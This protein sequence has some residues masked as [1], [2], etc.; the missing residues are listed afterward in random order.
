MFKSPIKREELVF[1]ASL[2]AQLIKTLRQVSDR[3]EFQFTFKCP[4]CRKA[5]PTNHSVQACVNA[6]FQRLKFSINRSENISP[7]EKV[8]LDEKADKIKRENKH[9]I[10]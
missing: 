5:Q 6:R 3:I 4:N 2:D 7:A 1:E 9:I 10:K 8:K